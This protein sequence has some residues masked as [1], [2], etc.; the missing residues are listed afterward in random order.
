MIRFP[1]V[2]LFEENI[3]ARVIRICLM[4]RAAFS[5][6]FRTAVLNLLSPRR[7]LLSTICEIIN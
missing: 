1:G 5:G 7:W 6:I 4:A 3:A 2:F